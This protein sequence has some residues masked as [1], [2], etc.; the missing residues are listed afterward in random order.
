MLVVSVHGIA[1]RNLSVV[2]RMRDDL[3][4]WGA[5]SVTLLAIPN[6]HGEDFLGRAPDTVDWLRR[7]AGAGDE[8]AVHGYY[9]RERRAIP[10]SA[11]L[12]RLR[13]R[14]LGHRQA[15]YLSLDAREQRRLLERGKI[16]VEDL[17]GQ[18]VRGFVAPA[19]QEPGTL[20]AALADT[21]FCWH[22]TGL[23]LEALPRGRRLRSP[24]I[25]FATGG[26]V[27]L[28]ASLLLARGLEPVADIAATL[29]LA[30]IRLALGP[31]EAG[32]PQVMTVVERLV[33]RLSDRHPAVT[34]SAALE[35]A[36]L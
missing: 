21:G 24:V 20:R 17:L 22:E 14:L 26:R 23:C 2:R 35:R 13:S 11:P 8:V 27:R 5:D 28:A 6:Y 34:A 19:W 10:I 12:R 25:G 29:G 3:A 9:H 15:E 7:C 16:L 36:G 32:N 1:P 31:K 4:R 18:E 33:R 30:P